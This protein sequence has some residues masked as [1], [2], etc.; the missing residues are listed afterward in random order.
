MTSQLIADTSDACDVTD[1]N[2]LPV[3]AF[4]KRVVT[5]CMTCTANWTGNEPICLHQ[6]GCNFFSVIVTGQSLFMNIH[7]IKLSSLK[8][9]N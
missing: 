2:S 8:A 9:I 4:V 5:Y 1:G 3:N 6:R 7:Y